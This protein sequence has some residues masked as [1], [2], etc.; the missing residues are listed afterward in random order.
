MHLGT[1]SWRKKWNCFF[2]SETEGPQELPEVKETGEAAPASESSE[3]DSKQ[4]TLQDESESESSRS[5]FSYDQLRAKSDNP[6]TGIDFKRREVGL[7]N[8]VIFI[9]ICFEIIVTYRRL[10]FS[11]LSLWRGVSDY[12]WDAERCFLSTAKVEARHAEEE[13]WFILEAEVNRTSAFTVFICILTCNSFILICVFSVVPCFLS[14]ILLSM[15]MA[16]WLVSVLIEILPEEWFS[17]LLFS[18]FLNCCRL[19]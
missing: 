3:D 1:C 17:S 11:D 18:L 8:V 9:N 2:F 5:T 10:G 12:I 4:K 14:S 15:N 7:V 16:P 13:S 19:L 6:V